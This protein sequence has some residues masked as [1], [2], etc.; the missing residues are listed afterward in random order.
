LAACVIELRQINASS[1][2][3]V[4]LV[5]VLPPIY[6]LAVGALVCSFAACV[7]QPDAPRWLLA[8][9]IVVFIIVV[10][11]ATVIVSDIPRGAVS[12]RHAGITDSLIESR[13]PDPQVDAYFNW[14]GFFMLAAFVTEAA[15]FSSA[16]SLTLLGPIVA[17]LLSI[18]PLM[19]IFRALTPNEQRCWLATWLFFCANWVNQDY[20]APQAYDLLLYLVVV[21]IVLT[22]YQS[23]PASGLGQEPGLV[24][25]VVAISLA[26]IPAH[27]LTPFALLFVV[28]GLVIV[29][30]CSL[31][32]LPMILAVGISG[33]LLFAAKAY[34]AG[35][36]T[37]LTAGIGDLSGAGAKNV[38]DRVQGS[39]G[40]L[41]VVRAGMFLSMHVWLL[42]VIG[43][44]RRYQSGKRDVAAYVLG[45]A[46]FLL[47]PLQPYG[48]ELL[49][50]VFLFTL[51]F[52]SFGVAGLLLPSSQFHRGKRL[53]V[54]TVAT[55]AASALLVISLLV[56]RFGNDT[57]YQFSEA[58]VTATARMYD[59]ATKPSL[60]VATAEHTPWKYRDYTVHDYRTLTDLWA[61]GRKP[62][63]IARDLTA[64]SSDREVF[65]LFTRAADTSVKLLGSTP[66]DF[67][68]RV[69]LAL[70][71]TPG[72]SEVYSNNDAR[73][74]H[75]ASRV[76]R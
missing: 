45:G 63:Q 36:I 34:V 70:T 52:M 28:S 48:G 11:G 42:A 64:E 12:W 54:S 40:H 1:M 24:I 20:F 10:Y 41:I 8:A 55:A 43:F 75:Y 46:P 44:W 14:P 68:R 32:L 18:G 73:L 53:I 13:R 26:M 66:S 76:G 19:L 56:A 57:I 2:T 71:R 49:L 74:Y 61:E 37:E 21:A 50:R 3:D 38:L 47:L 7:I 33:W 60:L 67:P 27:Q 69:E 29:R 62:E 65:V 72:W 31:C 15:G 25:C 35:H 30:R 16:L 5:S 59:L 17:N 6:W 58:E 22:W 23:Q 9:H 39:T 4:G 51:P